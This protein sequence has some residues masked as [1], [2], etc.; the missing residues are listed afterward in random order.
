MSLSPGQRWGL[1]VNAYLYFFASAVLAPKS[2]VADEGIPTDSPTL[3]QKAEGVIRNLTAGTGQADER[4]T[5][6]DCFP[7]TARFPMGI[8][9]RHRAL[10]VMPGN[11]V[12]ELTYPSGVLARTPGG[13]LSVPQHA[14]TDQGHQDLDAACPRGLH[15]SMEPRSLGVGPGLLSSGSSLRRPPFAQTTIAGSLAGKVPAEV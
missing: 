4:V 1:G 5:L 13:T 10:T 12:R 9:V 2:N 11:T 8:H 7:N 6:V 14:R 15:P 3:K